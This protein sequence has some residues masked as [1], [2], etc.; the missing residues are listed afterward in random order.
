MAGPKQP[1]DLR[2]PKPPPPPPPAAAP[3]A[4]G[5]LRPPPGFLAPG[6]IIKPEHLT[7][8]ERQ[9]LEQ[10]GVAPGTPVPGDLADI[11]RDIRS[12]SAGDPTQLP[13]P[14]DFRVPSPTVVDVADLTPQERAR[15]QAAISQAAEQA[16]R[17]AEIP[18]VP[19]ASPGVNEAIRQ[20]EL[21]RSRTEPQAPAVSVIDDRLTP[22]SPPAEAPT[23]PYVPPGT[24]PPGAVYVHQGRVD[25]LPDDALRRFAQPPPEA[26]APGEPPPGEPPPGTLSDAGAGDAR[27]CPHCG[28]DLALPD[29]IAPTDAD[30]YTFLWSILGGPDKRFTKQHELMGGQVLLNFRTL[31]SREAD[32][33]LLQ[34]A[35]DYREG[36]LHGNVSWMQRWMDYRLSFALE[37]I[38]VARVGKTYIGPDSIDEI[39]YDRPVDAEGGPL[40]GTPYPALWEH[41]ESKHLYNESLRRA[42]SLA[43]ASFVDLT[44]K[45]ENNYDNP[46]FWRGI[47]ARA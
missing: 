19:G 21:S 41:L 2:R 17:L 13:V 27:A 11:I 12:E 6:Q 14:P 39:E 33:T 4:G 3:A 15:V 40:P 30:K 10:L 24:M 29:G 44:K 20:A 36:K 7:P 45:L 42:V 18:T 31:T 26:P 25:T 37:S 34:I 8:Y 43:Y 46:D 9:Q 47:E 23:R 35:Q 32:L 16:R 38:T 22:K 1:F 5:G 28:W